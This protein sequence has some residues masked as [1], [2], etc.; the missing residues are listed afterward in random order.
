MY[1]V[2]PSGQQYTV[3]NPRDRG[4]DCGQRGANAGFD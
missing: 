2:P 4:S 3:T 1:I